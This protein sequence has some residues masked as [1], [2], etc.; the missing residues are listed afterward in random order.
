MGGTLFF[1]LKPEWFRPYCR[2]SEKASRPP[3]SDFQNPDIFGFSY[4]LILWLLFWLHIIP[5]WNTD[6]FVY[7]AVTLSDRKN[8]TCFKG[9]S[10]IAHHSKQIKTQVS[11][12]SKLFPPLGHFY[13]PSPL[14]RGHFLST[15]S[16]SNPIQYAPWLWPPPPLPPSR[17]LKIPIRL[18][19]SCPAFFLI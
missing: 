19:M 3:H 10:I 11:T 6:R 7:R 16:L 12:L 8:G 13:R 18:L 5:Q 2:H 15:F 9:G 14:F 1:N 17:K 4:T